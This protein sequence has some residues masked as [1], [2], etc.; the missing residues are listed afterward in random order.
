MLRFFPTHP[1]EKPVRH[2]SAKNLNP[3]QLTQILNPTHPQ[4]LNPK[5]YKAQATAVFRSREARARVLWMLCSSACRVKGLGFR[6][7]ESGFEV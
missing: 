3:A 5:P 6:V 2:A 4:T 1:Q 7:L